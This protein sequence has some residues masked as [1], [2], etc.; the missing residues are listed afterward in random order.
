LGLTIDAPRSEVRLHSPV[1]PPFLKSL[2]IRKLQVG[3]AT[4]DLMLKKQGRDV[5]VNLTRR[6][7]HVEL[8]TVK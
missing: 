5:S 4:I 3:D 8:V 1:L 7:G 2:S 6:D